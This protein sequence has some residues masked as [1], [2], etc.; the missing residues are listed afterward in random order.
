MTNLI[1]TH[2]LT[3][4]IFP[5]RM[6]LLNEF[7]RDLRSVRGEQILQCKYPTL[8][9]TRWVYVAD[10]FRFILKRREAVNEVRN[11]LEQS[12]IPDSLVCLYWILF[13]F[14][15]FSLSME[16][17]D[18][19]L[20]EVLPIVRETVREFQMLKSRIKEDEDMEMI[21]LVTAHFLASGKVSYV[22]PTLYDKNLKPR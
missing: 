16:S 7:I 11:L 14:K 21:N 18:R 20:G 13:S 3:T 22:M 12:S 6:A 1:F 15:L 5:E 10:V 8:V 2:V 9:R 19:K 4:E 17:R